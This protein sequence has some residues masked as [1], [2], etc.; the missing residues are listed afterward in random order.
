MAGSERRLVVNVGG[1]KYATSVTTLLSEANSYFTSMLG[2]DWAETD[3]QELFIDRD[4]ELFKH[5]LRFLRASPE[6]RLQIVQSLTRAEK[7][8]LR[9]EASVFQLERLSTLL[10][11][12]PERERFK[13]VYVQLHNWSVADPNCFDELSGLLAENWQILHINYARPQNHID[14]NYTVLLQR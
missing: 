9:E 14:A 10:Q 1:T 13:V 8:L 4:G 3:Q 5:V 7:A 6:G 11:A 2:G 12:D